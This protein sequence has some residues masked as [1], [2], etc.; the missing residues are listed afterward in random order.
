MPLGG[1][2]SLEDGMLAKETVGLLIHVLLELYEAG[3][4]QVLFFMQ[5]RVDASTELCPAA[6]PGLHC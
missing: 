4:V 2:I 1:G 3:E 5:K 6:V